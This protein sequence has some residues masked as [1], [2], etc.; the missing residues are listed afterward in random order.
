M[1]RTQATRWVDVLGYGALLLFSIE[2]AIVLFGAPGINCFLPRRTARILA[3]GFLVL[4]ACFTMLGFRRG[5]TWSRAGRDGAVLAVIGAV[6]LVFFMQWH[7][8]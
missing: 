2:T 8:W 7:R 3:A 4:W 1:P 6:T 5:F